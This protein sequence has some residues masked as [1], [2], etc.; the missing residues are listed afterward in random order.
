[1]TA[2]TLTAKEPAMQPM[3]D[4]AMQNINP[5]DIAIVGMSG[6][7][8]GARTIDEFWRNLRDGVES[9]R[10]MSDDELAAAGVPPAL[11]R[12]PDYVKA[13]AALDDMEMFDAP[14][15][16]FNPKE[17][18]IMDPQHRLFLECAWE[19]LESAGH[20]PSTFPGA[21]GVFAGCG[22]QAYMMYNLV[23]NRR[24]MDS[25]GLFLVRHT[26]NDKDF[27]VTRVSYCL[28][29]KGPAINVQT[30]CSTSLVAIHLACQS[31]L[32]GECD[33]ALAGGVTIELPHR[34]GY[35]YKDGEI[36]SPDG[37]CRTFDAASQG[38]VFGSGA[39][40][41]TLRRLSDAIADGDH[42]HAVIRGSAINNDGAGKVGYLA[43]SVDGQAA[44]IAEAIAVA[45]VGAETIGYIEAHGT[46]TPVG[47]PIEIT[48]L[49]QAF[50]AS[51]DASGYCAIG[52][53]KS[54]IGHLDTA[55]G[56]A[57]LIK[58]VEALK[59]RQIPPSLHFTAPNPSI[60]FASSPFF[61]N[62]S[63]RDWTRNG[64]P[65]RAG[66]SSLGVGGTNAHVVVEEAPAMRPSG[67]S[68]P[69]QLL[70]L[71]AKT[72]DSLDAATAN[73]ADYFV[74]HSGVALPDAAYTLQAGR[75]AMRER[76]AMVCS[77]LSDAISTLES[78]A[79]GR[80]VTHSAEADRS[81]SFMFAGGGA[82]Y[83]G[84]G[85]DLYRDEP[86]YRAAVDECL[87]LLR[88]SLPVDLKSLLYPAD[89]EKAHAAAQLERPSIALPALFITQYALA[90]L[91]MS[92]GIAPSSMIGHSM[93]EYTAAHL[94]G[95]FSLRDALAL[96]ALRGRLF[97]RVP[98]GG[99]L[100][101]PLSADELRPL[102]G[103]ELSIAAIN[104][105]GLCVASGPTH[106]LD[107]L[108]KLLAAREVECRRVR[109]S[110]AA[111]SAMLEPILKEFGDFFQAVRMSA[112]KIPFVSNLSGTW[113]TPEEAT[114]ASYWVRHLRQ[115]V[116]FAD[117]VKLLLED[118]TRVLLEVG[119]GRTLA[120]LAKQQP[121]RVASQPV[122]SSMRHPD[123]TVSDL[124]F[125]LGVLGEMWAH[126]VDPDWKGFWG[127]ETRQRIPLPT[128][129]FQRQRHWI[130]AVPVV[131]G[132]VQQSE[133]GQRKEDIAD[134]FY[135][136]AWNR[137][138]A[139]SL[140]GTRATTPARVLVLRDETGLGASL[141]DRL[142]AAGHEVIDV[143]AGEA[144][145]RRSS[146]EF[147][148][149]P[150]AEGDFDR[151]VGALVAEG[152]VPQEVVHLWTLG[153]APADRAADGLAESEDRAFYSLL[154]FA[155]ALGREDLASPLRITAVSS[156]LQRVGD[157]QA[158][159][160]ERALLLGPVHV[161]PREYPN[162]ACRSI[163]VVSA[164]PG[165][166][167][168]SRLVDQL[169]A[170]I[171]SDGAESVV[172]Y[173]GVDR[174]VQRFEPVSLPAGRAS[175]VR[176]GGVYVITGGLGGM[177]L[178]L[179]EHL[180]RTARAKL[181]L[182]G[183]SA[184]PS[185]DSWADWIRT[186]GTSDRTAQIIRQL[187]S[188]EATGGQV[189]VHQADITDAAQVQGA[190]E[191]AQSEFGTI[192]GVLHAAGTIDD[193]V[194]QLKTRD[195]AARVLAPKVRG[196]LLLDEA[197]R[198]IPLDFFA[199]F[200]SI[201]S[202]AGIAGQVDYAAANA[203]LDAFAHERMAR[204]GSLTV[205]IGW[206]SWQQVGM[207]A[208]LAGGGAAAPSGSTAP[209]HPLLER[210]VVSTS[211]EDL[212]ATELG[213]GSH[214]LLGE[215]RLRGG[216]ALI[217]GTGYLEIARAAV[218]SGQ[219]AGAVEIR[220][221]AF[222]SPFV[223]EDDERRELRVHVRRAGTTSHFVIAGRTT[224]EDGPGW[225]EHVTGTAHRVDATPRRLD[226]DAIR[227]RCGHRSEFFS[228]SEENP[229]LDF[230]PRWRNLS[231]VDFGSGEALAA[232]ELPE[233]YADDLADY[234]LHPALLDMATACAQSLVPG[235]DPAVDFFVPMSY[236][237]LRILG[238]LPKR[239]FSHVR[240]AESDLDPREI[241]VFDVTLMDEHGV[242]LVD[243]GEFMMT[244]ISDHDQLDGAR[245]AHPSRRTHVQLDDPPA[246]ASPASGLEDAI[247][248]SE[249]IEVFQR[250]LSAGLPQLFVAWRDIDSLVA[251]LRAPVAAPAQRNAAAAVPVGE[252]EAVLESHPAV[253]SG[254]VLARSD[255]TGL[256]RLVA[257]VVYDP[258]TQ[259]TV[260]ELRR[261]MKARLPDSQVPAAFIGMESI[262]VMEDGSVDRAALPDPFGSGE[263]YVP[264]ATEMQ[265]LIAEVWSEVLGIE[266]VSLHDNFFDIGGH[267]L[268]AVRVVTKLDKKIGVRLNQA[269]MVLQTLEQ[270]AAECEKR[271]GPRSDNPVAAPASSLGRKLFN[272]IRQSV[273]QS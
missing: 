183:R 5:T 227:V 105:P 258:D 185:R 86:V 38:T 8:P 78:P 106:A 132:E 164:E 188:I 171:T 94:A 193:G 51:T 260:S 176:E 109:I 238:P 144:F 41:V 219:D 148:V 124:A 67:P 246:A 248:P 88:S 118:R 89:A 241:A 50:R 129:A 232:I 220:D 208:A 153:D 190:V 195:A 81:I 249:G 201:S 162:V 262:P 222:M 119:P 142:R 26:G 150:S 28:D 113:I 207:A 273:M 172:A 96:V 110:I 102:L 206:S 82:Q 19:A 125:V 224:S 11:L 152:R 98:Q 242:E 83:P 46:A 24:L 101:V 65:R 253:A 149:A 231:R 221:V 64:T 71:S 27:L 63:L 126:G 141:S 217:P 49:T 159:V 174:W 138:L 4:D 42:I 228:G 211:E 111:H 43:P 56:V 269:V 85:A 60:D 136:P 244:R 100:S 40:V 226:L 15:F 135:Q 266:K 91:W 158:L 61:V 6:R 93:G 73:L 133:D 180:A 155:Q 57:G 127:T 252:I 145:A 143:I 194:L 72:T 90:K 200:S 192:N 245:R 239:L 167:R 218:T 257:Y 29:L 31:L 75:T 247:R 70:M 10:R 84:M 212:F 261:F 18:S 69:W 25:T 265:R 254:T 161:I 112:P 223:V 55:A 182:V 130:D 243:I 74:E 33:M 139:P 9:V 237:R 20:P 97:E 62:A 165:G 52:S 267:S 236:T 215:H 37:H 34:Q 202:V 36:L 21:I 189:L 7:F 12:D 251:S 54:N 39:G 240:L 104:A 186:H 68:R 250:A 13:S 59:H 151:L 175:R 3:T 147:V 92:W 80:V 122:L 53:V 264:P 166:W 272:S 77:D 47:D 169:M 128:Y 76:R 137:S 116:R 23:P 256:T 210:H 229:H 121:D 58:T 123:D 191:R 181:V 163:D 108:E 225:Q 216:H 168:E 1:M 134:W 203:Y 14:F 156:G 177:G 271:V 234:Q 213:I 32:S 196:T 66:I 140:P 99:M 170:E 184:F 16:G 173:R 179:A 107:A 2:A 204:E 146:G 270:I 48:A 95:V 214:W 187:M 30:A 268:L 205:A 233:K 255:R 263:D 120:T 79:P 197:L 117:G 35:L 157:E 22:M 199:V 44:A 178:V 115:T 114:D 45:D 131:A 230:G 209:L 198:G 235:V 103:A 259:A 154:A 87:T 17:A 160:P